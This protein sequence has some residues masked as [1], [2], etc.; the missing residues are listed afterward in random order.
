MTAAEWYTASITVNHG[1][2]DGT[3]TQV[4]LHS[5]HCDTTQQR[6]TLHSLRALC[7]VTG[8][9]TWVWLRERHMMCY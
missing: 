7:Y 3:H 9:F 6:C 4:T 1:S 5:T 8:R 2:D